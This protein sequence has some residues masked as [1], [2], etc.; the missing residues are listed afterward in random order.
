MW[1]TLNVHTYYMYYHNYAD[2]ILVL[3]NNQVSDIRSYFTISTKIRLPCNYIIITFTKAA[4][5]DTTTII[6][7]YSLNPYSIT[8]LLHH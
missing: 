4:I 2:L 8:S 1:P 5:L 6:V 3:L 7:G